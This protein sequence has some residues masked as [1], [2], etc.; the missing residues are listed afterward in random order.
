[1]VD[2]LCCAH[3]YVHRHTYT[4]AHTYVHRVNSCMY[5]YIYAFKCM[6]CAHTYVRGVNS[7]MYT[8][9]YE[10]DCMCCAHTAIAF[11]ESFLPFSNLKFVSHMSQFV[12]H[13][14]QSIAFGESFLQ[15]RVSINSLVLY[16]SFATFRLNETNW[17]EIGGFDGMALHTQWAVHAHIE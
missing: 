7:R 10:F 14:S 5:T 16:V 1:M 13:M 4:E 9:V 11:G 12:S 8:Y 6:C 2:V 15:S 17:I 3:T